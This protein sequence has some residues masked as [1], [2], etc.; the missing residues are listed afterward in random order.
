MTSNDQVWMEAKDREELVEASGTTLVDRFDVLLVLV[1][2]SLAVQS[3]IDMTDAFR[4]RGALAG[5]L[6]VTALVGSTMI[7]ALRTA[8]LRRRR[9]RPTEIFLVVAVVLLGLLL[10]LQL[11]AGQSIRLD[12]TGGAPW[13]WLALSLMAPIVVVRRLLHHQAVTR[14]TL[15]GAMS[16][17]LLIAIALSFAFQTVGSLETTPF[18]GSPQPTTTFIYYSLVTLTTV[19]YGDFAAATNFGR[20]LSVFGAVLGQVYLVTVVAMVVG[21]LAQQRRR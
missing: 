17:Y 18:F 14:Q 16:G 21:L 15:F 1:V 2:A 10:V 7:V 9:R 20:M 5:A 4:D 3:L 19:G 11:A 13:F 8:G 6:L 12:E